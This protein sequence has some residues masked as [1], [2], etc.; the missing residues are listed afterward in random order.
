[1]ITY[2]TQCCNF[3]FIGM[4]HSPEWNGICRNCN[5]PWQGV[6]RKNMVSMNAIKTVKEVYDIDEDVLYDRTQRSE[7]WLD[8]ESFYHKIKNRLANTL[9]EKERD[10]IEKIEMDLAD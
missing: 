4:N 6:Y 7:Y 5:N 1:M 3:K 9:T 2:Y 8:C 10:W